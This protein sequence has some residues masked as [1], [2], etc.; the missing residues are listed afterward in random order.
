MPPQTKPDTQIATY[1]C[2]LQA[3]Y[4]H[5]VHFAVEN[6]HHFC[7]VTIDRETWEELDQP[8]TMRVVLKEED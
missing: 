8:H 1:S 3:V 7:D 5:C 2:R 6:N 4:E